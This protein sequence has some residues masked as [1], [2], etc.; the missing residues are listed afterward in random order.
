[1]NCPYVLLPPL[2]IAQIQSYQRKKTNKADEVGTCDDGITQIYPV[3]EPEED[4]NTH[5]YKSGEAQV[6]NGFMPPDL[7]DLG[8]EGKGSKASGN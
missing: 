4:A 2:F 6:L 5:L 3:E 7:Y 8:D 1:M